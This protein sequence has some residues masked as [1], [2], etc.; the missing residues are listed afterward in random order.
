[1]NVPEVLAEGPPIV[2]ITLGPEGSILFHRRDGKPYYFACPAIEVDATD[3]TG[4]GD[5]FSAGFLW[6]HLQC[7]DAVAA[8]CAG[9]IVGGIN[10]TYSGIGHLEAARGALDQIPK[11]SP[12]LADKI[13]SGWPGEPL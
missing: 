8:N 4:C 7:K 13:A 2:I 9:N 12:D 10:C 3:T 6:N 11:W 5:S 1:M